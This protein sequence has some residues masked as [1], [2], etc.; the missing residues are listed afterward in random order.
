[1]KLKVL[2]ALAAVGAFASYVARADLI[3]FDASDPNTTWW[4]D[5]WDAYFD[6]PITD[7]YPLTFGVNVT[8]AG[9]NWW[10]WV[11]DVTGG[12]GFAYGAGGVAT[13]TFDSPVE[14]P[15]FWMGNS[16]DGDPSD[17]TIMFFLGGSQ[18]GSTIAS[19]VP[20]ATGYPDSW[21]E[22][23]DGVGLTIDQIVLGGDFTEGGIDGITVNQ[24][25]EPA[26]MALVLMGF[27]GLGLA[28][29]RKS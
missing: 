12:G 9:L 21:M 20:P 13:I 7:A 22:V 19:P 1:M 3:T 4:D 5:H 6:S 26:T 29:R 10:P 15:S 23:T 25:P 16:G 8:F 28:L 2:F 17:D 24:I 27:A 11:A 14:V 18:V